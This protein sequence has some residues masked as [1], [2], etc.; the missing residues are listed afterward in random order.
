MVH[1]EKWVRH[2]DMPGVLL[3]DE[4]CLGITF[5]WVEAAMTCKQLTGEDV[6]GL[7]LSILWGK[8]LVEWMN[9][10][11]NNF[12][13]INAD[14]RE[15]Y[16]LLTPNYVPRCH[17]VIQST[18]PRVYTALPSALEPILVVP[19]PRVAEMFKSL[20]HEMTYGTDVNFIHL[21]H[22]NNVNITQ[23]D[24]NTSN[25]EPENQWNIHLVLY[26]TLNSRAKPSGNG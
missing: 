2:S 3:L 4:M 5:T 19:M 8:T 17:S 22:L 10:A 23:W 16:P 13:G 26:E 25:D 15:W 7:L 21:L 6:I 24:L 14:E 9:M 20:I 11:Q 12:P 1:C 18:P